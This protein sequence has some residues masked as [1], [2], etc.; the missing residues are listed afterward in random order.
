MDDK[1]LAQLRALCA[2]PGHDDGK[3]RRGE[4]RRRDS[5]DRKLRQLCG[6]VSRT[7]GLA[8][9]A[10]SDP[11][12]NACWVDGVEPAPDASRL[13]VRV[14]TLDGVDVKAFVAALR[15][16]TP[17]LRTEVAASLQRKRTP[18]LVV[19]WAGPTPRP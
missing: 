18:H 8:L 1:L 14:Q 3:P 17:W 11:L 4:R 19:E 6:A 16:A 13:R 10:S 12:L 5:G 9:G 2:E 15:S 7:V